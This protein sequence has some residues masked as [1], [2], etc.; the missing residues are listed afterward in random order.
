MDKLSRR[1]EEKDRQRIE[2]D[3]HRLSRAESDPVGYSMTLTLR[4]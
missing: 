1:N 3:L 4:N 2:M